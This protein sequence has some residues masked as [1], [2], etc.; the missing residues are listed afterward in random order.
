MAC[1]L[2]KQK[3]KKRNFPTAWSSWE[4]FMKDVGQLLDIEGL[5]ENN[6]GLE[7]EGQEVKERRSLGR[8]RKG[9]VYAL[10]RGHMNK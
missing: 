6:G 7:V 10:L 4:K 1:E 9:N 8:A 2:E 3:K 5:K